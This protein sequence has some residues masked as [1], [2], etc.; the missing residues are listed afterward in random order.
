M[1]L[2]DAHLDLAYLAENGRDLTRAPEEAGGP[3]PPAAVTFGELRV[4]GVEAC[5]A[6]IFTEAGGADAVAYPPGDAPAAH[7][8]GERQLERYH[9]WTQ[10]GWMRPLGTRGG[11]AGGLRMGLLMEGADPIRRPEELPWW[12]GRGVICIGMAWARGSRYATGNS[13]ESGGRGAGLSDLGRELVVG[14]DR[15]GLVHDASHLSDGALQGLL[16]LSQGRVIAS[17]S[18]CRALAEPPGGSPRAQRHL[19]DA[20]IREI[21]RRGGVIGLNLY[22]PFVRP[23]LGEK[24]RPTIEEALDHVEHIC[25]LLGHRRAVG[26][27]SDLDGGFGAERLPA[28]INSARDLP[29]LGEA[30]R[31]RGWSDADIHAFAWGNWAR[32]WGL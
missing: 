5:L 2:F 15:L 21:A 6:T 25:A 23:R 22:A 20:T 27:G 4:G 18:N 12:A 8:A 26:L 13:R 24:E 14:I 28:G 10:Q 32:F 29:K 11:R 3:H 9:A 17:H 30:L 16:S 7:L 1:R 31:T 19:T